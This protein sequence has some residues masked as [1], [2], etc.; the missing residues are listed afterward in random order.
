MKTK[1]L[2]MAG[3]AVCV[4]AL[5]SC[6]AYDDYGYAGG[7]YYGG[8]PLVSRGVVVDN[9]VGYNNVGWGGGWGGWGGGWG[10]WGGYPA[11]SSVG[12]FG[13]GGRGFGSSY[14]DRGHHHHG[15]SGYRQSANNSYASRVARPSS[16]RGTVTS[17]PPRIPSVSAPR[18][19]SRPSSGSFSRPSSSRPSIRS[20]APSIR[21][22]S[23][24]VTTT[25]SRPSM[26]RSAP[27]SSRPS[28][29]RP[30][31]SRSSSSGRPSR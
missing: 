25:S 30:S 11:Y 18:Q 15:H 20:S 9:Y 23:P 16:H 17:A 26:S 7:G 29:S 27:S 19:L 22:S 24:R 31:S 13:L 28:M 3:V 2:S 8:A 4:A 14:Y 12:F 1:L 5:S 21:P 6:V 10:G